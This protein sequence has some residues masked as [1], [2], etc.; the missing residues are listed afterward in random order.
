MTQRAASATSDVPGLPWLVVNGCVVDEH[1]THPEYVLDSPY[2]SVA[3]DCK[4]DTGRKEE[5]ASKAYKH[6]RQPLSTSCYNVR[7]T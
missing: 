2:S 1:T 3:L 6:K 7:R 4:M 5:E